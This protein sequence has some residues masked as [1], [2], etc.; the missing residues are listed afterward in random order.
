MA[1]NAKWSETLPDGRVRCKL[2]PRY[3][4]LRDGQRGF[5][6]VRKNEGGHLILDTY[7]RSSGFA[8]DPVEKKPEIFVDCF[9]THTRSS[10]KFTGIVE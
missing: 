1:F 4:T 9:L 10:R 5:C 2:C 7:G 6:F 3:C 8:V